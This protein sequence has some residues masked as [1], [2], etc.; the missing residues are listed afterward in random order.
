MYL[1]TILYELTTTAV[2]CTRSVTLAGYN[3]GR[4]GKKTTGEAGEIVY[5]F[6]VKLYPPET[7]EAKYAVQQ[8]YPTY[9]LR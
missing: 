9:P 8:Q 4:P 6:Q 5:Y 1:R 2:A 7:T 3:G